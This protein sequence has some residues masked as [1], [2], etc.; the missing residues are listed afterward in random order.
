MQKRSDIYKSCIFIANSQGGFAMYSDKELLRFLVENDKIDLALAQEKYEMLKREELLS[1]HPYKI[2]F[3]NDGYWHTYLPKEEGSRKP[4]KKKIQRDIEDEVIQ[5]WKIKEENPTI[6]E[7]FDIYNRS[8]LESKSISAAS[9]MRYKQDF[10]RFYGPWK[11]RRIREVEETELCDFIEER[12]TELNLTN[13][14]FSNFKTITKGLFKRAYRKKWISFRVEEEVLQVIDLSE[15]SFQKNRKEDYQEVFSEEEYMEYT[16]YLMEH[17]DIWNIAL[18]LI[19]I[20]GL[21]GGEIVALSY[22]DFECKKDFYTIS[23]HK[24][25]TRYKDKNNKY[26]YEVKNDPKSEASIRRAIVPKQY[27]WICEKLL[28]D[29]KEGEFVFVNPNKGNRLTTNSLRRRQ[30]RNCKKLKYYQKSPHKG[31]KTYCSI[32]MDNNLDDNLV[33]GQMGHVDIS[34]SEDFYHRNMKN[35]EKKAEIISGIYMFDTKIG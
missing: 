10:N 9:H 11:N 23:V 21:R 22:E 13:K 34:T 29:K 8:R 7:A 35:I 32:L 14:S 12:V 28:R 1:K 5:F 4:L 18:L 31:R 19:L 15:N 30:E 26:V 3:G 17:L 6:E 24:T 25:E 16:K 20:T 27:S 2:S 33:T